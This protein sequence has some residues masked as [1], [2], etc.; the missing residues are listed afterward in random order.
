MN[1]HRLV[2]LIVMVAMIVTGLLPAAGV[3]AAP[4]RSP[5]QVNVAGSFE[6]SIGGSNWSNN[7]PLTDMTDANGDGVWKFAA[8]PAA[9]DYEYK[10][11]ENGDWGTSFPAE[12]VAF[13]AAGDEVTWRYDENDHF[14]SDTT[15]HVVA[16]AVGN[17]AGAIGGADWSPDNLK[18]W[19]K[20]LDG[21]GVYT[22]SAAIPAGDYE[23]KVALNES[24]DVSFPGSN[25]AF[26]VPAGGADVTFYYDSANN[27]VWEE[28]AGGVSDADLVAEPVQAAIQDEVM[29]FVLPDRF[30]NGDP[31]NDEGAFP[32]GTLAE[33]GFLPTDKSFYHGGDLAGLQGKL[34][35]LAGLG[36]TSIW[37]TPVLKNAPTGPDG[38]TS[39]GIGG[40]YHGYWILDF[41]A[42][43]P[44]QGTDAEL[45]AFVAEA[46]ANGIR[47]F[48]D[49]VVNHTADVI[50]YAE[51]SS[52][53]RNKE[54]YPF[55]DAD[56]VAFDDMDY[57]GTGTFPELDPDVSFPY[58]PVFSEPGDET[59]KNPAWL[60][61]RIYYHNRGDSTFSGESSIY[62]D[63]FGLDDLFTSHP[64]VISGY[65]DI[66][67]NLIDTY[68]IDG[69]RLDTV[70][71][72]HIELWQELAPEVIAYAQSQ[73]KADFTMFGEVFDGSAEAMSRFTTAGQIP[74]VLDFGLHGTVASVGV[75]GGPT[76]NLRNLFAADD[77]F[78][79]AD[80]NAY[81]LATF[82]SNH[83]IGRAGYAL[84]NAFPAAS[85]DE[86]VQRMTWGY[87]MLYFARGFPVVYYGDEQGFV[88]GGNDKLSRED[89][90]P[91]LV[92]DYMNNDLI[93]TDATPADAN[94]DTTHPLYQALAEL[95]QVRAD[96][97]A[98]RCGAQIHRYSTDGPGIYAFSR[99][100]R[101]EQIE[102]VVAF[103][104]ATADASATFPVYLNDT[105]YM[106]VYPAGGASLT[107]SV[108]GELTVTLPPGGVA[109]YK[110]AEA[111][112]PSDAAPTVAFNTPAAGA[113][114]NGRFEVGVD[115]STDQLA[116]V[117]FVVKVGNG[118]WELV[119]VDTNAPYRVFYD[120]SAL[121][122]GT[123]LLFRA[124]ANDL[125]EHLNGASLSVVVSEPPAPAGPKYALIHYYR[126]DGNYGDPTSSNYNDFWGLH[127]WGDGVATSSQTQWTQPMPFFGEDDYGV[128]AWVEVGDPTQPINFIVHRGD[129]KD[130]PNSP[131]RSFLIS[132][133]PQ[134][135]LRQNDVAVYTSQADAQGY[136]TVRYHRPDGD[137]GDYTSS[138][139]EDFWGLHLW[140]S[141]GGLT[142][143]DNPKRADG[144]DE[145]GAYFIINEA[146]YPG[147]LDFSLP[148]NFIVHRGNEKD[149]VDSPDRSFDPSQFAT[150]WLQSGD[151]EVYTQQGAA[152]GF[153]LL[154]YRRPAG[155]YGDYTS[156]NYNDFW[157]MHA[158]G[159]ITNSVAWDNPLRP[160]DQDTF[161]V[162]F[163]VDL[164]ANAQQVNYIF[165]RGD[166]KDPGPD[167]FLILDDSGY[168]VWQL[169][170]ADPENPYVRPVPQASG[171]GSAGDI[172]EQRAYW[173]LDDTIA[174]EDAESAANSYLLCYAPEGGLEATDTGITGGDCVDLTRDP[175]GL[176]QEVREKMPHIADLPALKIS[177][178][179][180]D[181][182]PDMLRS[183][184]AVSALD[185]GG[186][187]QGATGLQI[188]GVLD[189]LFT[190][191]GQLGVAWEGD[192]PVIR[193][194]APT[195]KSVTFH[196]FAD[197][198]PATT[199]T[200]YA[201]GYTPD[202]GVWTITGEP[203][204]EWQYYLFEVEVW[205]NSTQAVEN[206][207]VTDP[208]SFSLA[209]NSTRSQLVDL[210][211]PALK[212]AGWDDLE[213][214]ALPAAEDVSIYEL[215]V[216]DFS[217][218]DPSVPDD[219]K[220]TY[221]AFTLPD[222]N[223]VQH[224]QALQAAGLN[225]LHLLPTFDIATINEDKAQWLSPTFDE[226]RTYGPDS[227]QQQALIG[228]T[229]DDDAFNWGY[230]PLH[231]TTPEGSYSTDP[232]GAQRILEYREMVQAINQMGLR[233]VNDVVYNH[234]NSSGQS[235]LSVLDRIVPGYYHR[236]NDRGQVE[237]STCCQNTATEFNMMEKLMI[238]SV[239]TWAT[240][241]KIDSFRFDLMGHH[242]KR[243]MLK[244]RDELDALTPE[245]GGVVGE[246][247]YVYGEGWN[248]GEVADN[249]RGENATQFNMAG[250]GIGTFSDRLRDAVR[251]GGPFD[252]GED[253]IRR[254]GFANGQ[255]YDPNDLNSG[256]Q[257]ELDGLLHATDLT[258]LGMAGNLADYQLVDM[259]GN[260][261]TGA[262]ID[263]NGQ[264]A[265][266]T[267]DPQEQIIYVSKHDN[268]TLYDINAYKIP[269]GRSTAERSRAQIVGLSTVLLGQGVPFL[270]AGVD[271]L[272]SKSID[273][274]SYN[275]GDWFNRLDWTYNETGWGSGLPRAGV[276]QDNWP[277]IQPLLADPALNPAP[278]DI[279]M[280]TAML[281][282]LLALRYSSPL[283]RLQSEQEVMERVSFLNNGPDQLPG[284][285]VMVLSDEVEPDLDPDRE[286]IVVLVNANDEA[287][288][289][290]DASL[291]GMDLA[292]SSIQANGV[293][294][295]V[296][297]SAFDPATGAFSVPGR[298]TAVF[299]NPQM[300]EG[301]VTQTASTS[302]VVP[303]TYIDVTVN[304]TNNT[305]DDI[306]DFLALA[307]IDPDTMYVSGSAYGGAF[308]LTA[309]AALEKGMTD[310][311]AGRAPE[312]VVAVAWAGPFF[313]GDM[314]DF[315]FQVRV[316][317]SSG[318][319]QHDVA[320]FD[321]A[322]FLASLTSDALLI[323]DNSAYPVSRSRR[324]NSDRDTFINGA[325]PGAYFGDAQTMWT[326]Y[327]G[328]MRPL[329]HTPM[330]GIPGDAY[331]DVAYLY[332]YIVE[333]R[334]FSNWSNS[335]I[336]V[337]TH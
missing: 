68:D 34:D 100:E 194:W 176:P 126:E 190:Y 59:A 146:D 220:G 135:W 207:V 158:W 74:S 136:V 286:Q 108:G 236:L 13:T 202:S 261:V 275:S 123:A 253:L 125:N 112:S 199:S 284:L 110:A 57:V 260:L 310:L 71:H 96:N 330:D 152:E 196:L 216:R 327:F 104:S 274:D 7:D 325:Q 178:D 81:Q 144:I 193:L 295:L 279:A 156:A 280:T 235:E 246:E 335:V 269:V 130:P 41:E 174:W 296:K 265:G 88:G 319:V 215:H 312:D 121:A 179:D 309:A 288:T 285:I 198:D 247:I 245:N 28:V 299:T 270:H 98:L 314:V 40:S 287:Q 257:A 75:N 316:V 33:T 51:D 184:I 273:R 99:I 229:I 58:T 219:L 203:G 225:H 80:S 101:D 329:V 35:Y 84:R 234:T 221:K 239:L 37:M 206:N 30:A 132:E 217:V 170:G 148:L 250:T 15:R 77:Y 116:E 271:L 189:D 266:Y 231:Y 290:T 122:P 67:K 283:F 32:G 177:A 155:D 64:D 258:K 336:N 2:S 164:T 326:G 267:D 141:L 46:H 315:G 89:M 311:A 214:P 160:V 264:P 11:V 159:D 337:E 60:N 243:N 113:D 93:G 318:E 117:T 212:P 25:V 230:D 42:A 131:D 162:V 201:M 149:P 223:G 302:P 324:F 166:E 138:N 175:A 73:G 222:S 332:L 26:S 14:V 334:G 54:D 200:T 209:M 218:N 301:T 228:A 191:N 167:Q 5:A 249:A 252:G 47:I 39:F 281:Q 115:L 227:E 129:E 306:M 195:A 109:V 52:L 9:G 62:G 210:A 323:V 282:E 147:V 226:L 255:Y 53:Y 181:M 173:V 10:I 66:F 76:N 292:L 102:Y 322:T 4:L 169:Q 3:A 224:L 94:F 21:D 85:D 134:I 263:Y 232:D 244:L 297:T 268:Q 304:V 192:T 70:K 95:A 294:P 143:W 272:R 61:D 331:V 298:T 320:L 276:N 186:T 303:G 139:F 111:L 233:V 105:E 55:R 119:G 308:P 86:L 238:D 6:E 29:Y 157:G 48:F 172:Q 82:I 127:L 300:L 19:M 79:D 208:Y 180:L 120:A 171:G 321:G 63:F 259:N 211:D 291:V 151:V 140:T 97:L 36:V 187:A 114:V 262:Q 69:F 87:A 241:Y 161:G 118:D 124:I 237:T 333:G 137:Y 168:E 103:N 91:S 240:E 83:D 23:Y 17:F 22:F 56:G 65:T 24:W 38:S 31:S 27:D 188:Q 49:M 213:K 150:I 205:V 182:V 317:S 44:H 242:M 165:H 133:S 163:K 107:S 289:F 18:T 185:A 90:M 1:R 204:W 251:G 78:T 153:A 43:D 20:D 248:F 145:Y 72:V 8:T 305:P 50:N 16:T 313:N 254:Q 12:N 293:D 328:Q 256:S 106:A 142:D 45:Q 278:A 128:W 154:H 197:S 92:P 307:P 277:L 183:Q